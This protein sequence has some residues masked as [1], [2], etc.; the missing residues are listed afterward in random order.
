MGWTNETL[1]EDDGGPDPVVN[2]GKCGVTHREG[3]VCP[4]CYEKWL[5]GAGA[6]QEAARIAHQRLVPCREDD[7]RMVP[8]PWDEYGS[9]RAVTVASLVRSTPDLGQDPRYLADGSGIILGPSA[10]PLRFVD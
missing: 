1:F 3:R 7:T 8:D 4:A 10:R 2:C 6:A 9:G 5:A